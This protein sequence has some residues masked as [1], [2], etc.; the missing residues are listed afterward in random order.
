V[1]AGAGAGAGVGAGAAGTGSCVIVTVRPATVIE[2]LRLDVVVFAATAY[3][4]VPLPVPAFPLVTV[5]QLAPVAD[6]HG[7]PAP[8]V[9]VTA[10]VP[11]AAPIEADDGVS[12]YPHAGA[13]PLSACA[14][15]NVWLPIV[16]TPLRGAVPPLTST[17][18]R[19]VPSP[20]PLPP[21]VIV[22]HDT[23]DEVVHAQPAGAATFTEPVP[24]ALPNDADAALSA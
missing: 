19:T 3:D 5:I 18:N 12:V 20:L 13:A 1:G 24:A 22:T 7:Q 8:D 21:A 6:V 23:F 11:P 17:V 2:P 10:P 14:M 4:T 9:T 16:R 15:V